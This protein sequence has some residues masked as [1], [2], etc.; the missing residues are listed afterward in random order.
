MKAAAVAG[1]LALA[2]AALAQARPATFVVDRTFV[3]TPVATFGGMRDLDVSA[4]PP[5]RDP[6]TSIPANIFLKSGPYSPDEQLVAVRARPMQ[7]F[8]SN[9]YRAGV[10]ANTARCRLSRAAVP[11]S[12]RGLPAPPV[13]WGKVVD[14]MVRG[15]VLVHVRAELASPSAWRPVGART[16]AR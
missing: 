5:Y 8:G 11:L 6:Q 1:L 4:N 9:Q 15:R 2:L 10:Y 16:P 12:A 14:C 13:V 3:C 7:R